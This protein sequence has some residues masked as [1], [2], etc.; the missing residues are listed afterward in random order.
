MEKRIP[1]IFVVIL[2][3]F[4]FIVNVGFVLAAGLPWDGKNPTP[5]V[6]L[7]E[8]GFINAN[9]SG[10]KTA[11]TDGYLRHVSGDKVHD[12]FSQRTF[13]CASCHMTH[14]GQ[15]EER[16]F[17]TSV[18]NT[19][20]TCHFDD[21]ISTYNVLAGNFKYEDNGLIGSKSTTGGRFY[22]GEFLTGRNAV[23]FHLATGQKTI[24]NA[25]GADTSKPGWWTRPFSCGSCH[26]PHGSYNQS[27]H[28]HYN[29]NG[30]A[31]R[32][33]KNLDGV[34][35]RLESVGNNTYVPQAPY[36]EKKPWLFYELDSPYYSN[37]GVI[38]YNVDNGIATDVTN[39][40]FIH[41][42]EGYVKLIDGA[43]HPGY[44]IIEFSQ[45][46][47]TDIEV[48]NAGTKDENVIYRSGTVEFCTSC[49]TGYLTE[50]NMDG[51][52]YYYTVH[53]PFA[54][55]RENS[56]EHPIKIDVTTNVNNPLFRL[57]G[58]GLDNGTDLVC[59]SCHFAHG[60]D[61]EIIRDRN[62]NVMDPALLGETT[63]LL[64]FGNRE[65]C[66]ICHD[67]GYNSTL[68]V[69]SPQDQSTV[70]VSSGSQVQF[71]F[72][73]RIKKETLNGNVTVWHSV[74]GEVYGSFTTP[75]Y[76]TVYFT[77]DN[78]LLVGEEYTVEIKPG[79]LSWFERTLSKM[80]QFLLQ[81]SSN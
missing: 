66:F 12:S 21:T 23:S 17:Q 44:Y 47:K 2:L 67:S 57:E 3:S 51:Q 80:H 16:L 77:P 43:P 10:I 61:A 59:L 60:T 35:I 5:R 6:G 70:T 52:I 22:D 50:V 73:R 33:D 31:K 65:S 18:Y 15:N 36:N 30:Q 7:V 29:V 78:H 68:T 72:D 37:F 4:I 79:V 64:R 58:L 8:S 24:G 9:E 71:T 20:S 40:F 1:K 63:N 42:N 25:P 55:S 69:L 45:A 14:I 62:F 46:T 27:R 41:Y 49:H 76:L 81:V 11:D 54:T 34:E 19:C 74:Y 13:S 28:L 48:I 32:Y 38:I 75:D 39:D 56:F 53:Q 26:A